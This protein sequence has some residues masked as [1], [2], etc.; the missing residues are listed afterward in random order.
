L[1]SDR[2]DLDLNFLGG[3]RFRLGRPHTFEPFEQGLRFHLPSNELDQS[4]GI[5]K[6]RASRG[7]SQPVRE[8]DFN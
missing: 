8:L 2:I 4:I 5:E 7:L 1:C 3:H 6:P